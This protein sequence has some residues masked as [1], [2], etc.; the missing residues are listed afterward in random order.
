MWNI[1]TLWLEV[2]VVS[3]MF[4]FGNIFFG[5]FEEKTPN[6]RKALKYVLFTAMAVAVSIWLGREWSFVVLAILVLFVAYVHGIILPRHGINGLTGEPR[7]K[8]YEFRGWK[9]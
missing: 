4:A 1:D 7:D 6:W 9:K 8:Y 5:H 2:A 3:A